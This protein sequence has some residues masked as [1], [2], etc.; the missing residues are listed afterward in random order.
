MF[1]K[2]SVTFPSHLNYADWFNI[3][4][5]TNLQA[6]FLDSILKHLVDLINVHLI[7]TLS[8]KTLLASGI[9]QHLDLPEQLHQVEGIQHQLQDTLSSHLLMVHHGFQNPLCHQ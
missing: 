3:H 7:L 4:T 9:I 5:S 2:S 8:G 6:H 1:N